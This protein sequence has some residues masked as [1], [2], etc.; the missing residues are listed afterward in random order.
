MTFSALNDATIRVLQA[1]G[2]EVVVPEGQWCCGALAVHA[3]YRDVA[4]DLARRTLDVFLA[5]GQEFDA[6]VTNAAGCG[7]TMK[8]YGLLFGPESEDH[9][10]A[11]GFE[12]K[13]RDVTEFLDEQGLRAPMRR[14][15]LRATYQDSCHLLHGQKV[16]EAP[17][18]LIRAV[19]G[20]ELVEM[21]LSDQCCGS[22]GVYNVT[23][24][25]TAMALL[26]KKMECVNATTAQVILTANPGCLLQLRAG[27]KLAGNGQEVLHVVELLDRA[28][29][30]ERV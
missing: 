28:I 18:R 22:A 30:Q 14:A 17:R 21:E 10:R 19:E 8:E 7:S 25:D 13:L 2:C 3:G 27:A 4:R 6:I 24:T 29:E 11:K 9:E 5:D 26:R 20:V 15:P 1:N 12:D 16:R 23:Q